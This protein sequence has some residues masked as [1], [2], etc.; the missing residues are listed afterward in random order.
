[1]A[2]GFIWKMG[3]QSAEAAHDLYE[4][5][6]YCCNSNAERFWGPKAFGDKMS[7]MGFERLKRNGGLMY[8]Q[9]IKLTKVP[10]P[11]KREVYSAEG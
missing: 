2:F 9:G 1:M 5:Y 8:Y 11:P 4:A 7:E 6:K 10:E 3:P